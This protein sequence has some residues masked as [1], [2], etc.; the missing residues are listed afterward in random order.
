MKELICSL[1][2]LLGIPI[3]YSEIIRSTISNPDGTKVY[4]FYIEGNET[5]RQKVDRENNVLAVVGK[6]PDGIVK[7]YYEDGKLKRELE[8]KNG[9][10]EG[11]SR[12][13]YQSGELMYE[14]NYKG[15]KLEGIA[16]KYYRNGK[17][18]YEWNY[19]DGKRDGITKSSNKSGLLQVEWNFKDDRLDGITRIYYKDGGIQYIDTYR[20]GTKINR[21]AYDKKGKLEFDQ[22]YPFEGKEKNSIVES[23]KKGG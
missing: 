4:I 21:K 17:V 19:R 20:Q 13:Y 8:Y 9:A 6:I 3:A 18:A 10:L 7:E 11:I 5:A 14:Y 23:V 12:T 15:G 2:I 16:R 22:D 1:L